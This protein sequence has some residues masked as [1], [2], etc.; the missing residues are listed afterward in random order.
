MTDMSHDDDQVQTASIIIDEFVSVIK[1]LQC[2]HFLRI[3]SE[4]S[5]GL[6][7]YS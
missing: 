7:T 5:L 4:I 2:E 6:A 3:L 1:G